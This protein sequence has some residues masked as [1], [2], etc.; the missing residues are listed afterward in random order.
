MFT[1]KTFANTSFFTKFV[2]VL[3]R[4]TFPLYGTTLRVLDPTSPI[5]DV[6]VCM[7]L[8]C[9]GKELVCVSYCCNIM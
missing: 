9:V 2:K 7:H 4:K 1:N 6:G 3:V 5:V 8:G